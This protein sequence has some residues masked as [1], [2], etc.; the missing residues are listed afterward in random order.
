VTAPKAA[1]KA[2]TRAVAAKKPA[3]RAKAPPARKTVSEPTYTMPQDVRDWIERAQ[4]I[5]QHQKGLIERLKEENAELKT[6]RRW[7][8]DRILKAD[9]E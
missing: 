7:A 9:Y 2:K 5:M 6:W 3:A 4:S 8:E 1:A